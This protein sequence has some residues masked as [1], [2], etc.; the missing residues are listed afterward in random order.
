MVD[1]V[2]IETAKKKKKYH[3]EKL[4]RIQEVVE[5]RKQ[6]KLNWLRKMQGIG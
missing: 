2:T 5:H 3:M 6:K 4:T 1:P